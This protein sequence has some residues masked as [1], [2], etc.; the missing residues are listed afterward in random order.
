VTLL[1]TRPL[2]FPRPAVS[3]GQRRLAAW[4][5]GNREAAVSPPLDLARLS[6]EYGPR[7][8]GKP[9]PC[10]GQFVVPR[11]T[12]WAIYERVR[13]QKITTWMEWMQGQGWDWT[14]AR[15]RVR[16]IDIPAQLEDGT[17]DPDSQVMEV[18]TTFRKR[19]ER[20]VRVELDPVLLQ[21]T[22]PAGTRGGHRE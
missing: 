20:V 13:N 14:G 15:V 4:R 19:D 1:R 9:R 5:N 10:L 21:P 12:D 8:L 18:T 11:T 7:T 22:Y 3:P 6:A 16:P 2:T 17:P